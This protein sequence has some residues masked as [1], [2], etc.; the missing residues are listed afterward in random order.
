MKKKIAVI[1]DEED[2]L[3]LME[4]VLIM[5]GYD[6]ITDTTGKIFDNMV[7]DFPD[8]I[9]LDINLRY[10]DGRDICKKIK[11][12]LLTKDIPVIF[13][14][15]INDLHVITKTCGADDYLSKPFDIHE[16]LGKIRHHLH[17]TE[18]LL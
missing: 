1:E 7:N 6:V 13:L 2:I 14:S 3:M 12:N 10:L 15:A 17:N 9:I 18:I 8:L 11:E 16:L 4:A 5:Q